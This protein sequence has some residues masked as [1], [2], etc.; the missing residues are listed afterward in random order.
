M[1]RGDPGAGLVDSPRDAHPPEPS[2]QGAPSGSTAK[3]IFVVER[4][5]VGNQ[6]LRCFLELPSFAVVADFDVVLP[7]VATLG[8]A[9]PAVA[10]KAAGFRKKKERGDIVCSPIK[11]RIRHRML[12]PWMTPPP[13]PAWAGGAAA[14]A[15]AMSDRNG[16][17]LRTTFIIFFQRSDRQETQSQPRKMKRV[18]AFKGA[19]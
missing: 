5:C 16:D 14:A 7:S 12:Y 18:L 4:V 9:L 10:L 13:P 6:G 15:T 1:R 3:K 17:H 8:T 19:F 11:F 2:G